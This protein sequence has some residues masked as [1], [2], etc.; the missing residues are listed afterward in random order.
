[1][2]HATFGTATVQG[3]LGLV[4]GNATMPAMGSAVTAGGAFRV[5]EF[6]LRRRWPELDF[7]A[8]EDALAGS[9]FAGAA[10]TVTTLPDGATLRF[11]E[12]VLEL[13]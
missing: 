12:A 10:E 11:R 6:A 13:S 4:A 2:A 5:V 8:A 9:P 7:I 3:V 1:M